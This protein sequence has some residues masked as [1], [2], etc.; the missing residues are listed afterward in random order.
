MCSSGE[1]NSAGFGSVGCFSSVSCFVKE[2]SNEFF[3]FDT[4][5][6][7]FGGVFLLLLLRDT[8]KEMHKANKVSSPVPCTDLEQC[9]RPVGGRENVHQG[10]G[11]LWTRA[12][13]VSQAETSGLS[14]GRLTE[15]FTVIR[16][17]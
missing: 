5:A 12:I 3:W 10:P 6:H 4:L 8:I 17:N 9:P 15:H 2:L 14:L 1:E 11:L 7:L 13:L 16:F